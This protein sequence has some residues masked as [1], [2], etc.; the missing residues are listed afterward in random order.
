[1]SL[2][3]S[4][5]IFSAWAHCLWT[6]YDISS[7]L[8]LRGRT[9]GSNNHSCSTGQLEMQSS[10]SSITVP[11]SW[12]TSLLELLGKSDQKI[13]CLAK[14]SPRAVD[15]DAGELGHETSCLGLGSAVDW[16]ALAA[17]LGAKKVC[18]IKIWGSLLLNICQQKFQRVPTRDEQGY[19]LDFKG[20]WKGFG[21]F[22]QWWAQFNSKY[23]VVLEANV[24]SN[25]LK[26]VLKE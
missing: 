3:F 22:Y 25:V 11:S 2:F 5:T 19:T 7:F 13:T 23:N 24:V 9:W 6:W 16:A 8:S 17:G 21:Q 26:M 10:D 12:S 15:S 18:I 14:S 20:Y 1:M 4:W